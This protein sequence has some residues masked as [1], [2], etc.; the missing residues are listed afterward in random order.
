MV[1]CRDAGGQLEEDNT[2]ITSEIELQNAGIAEAKA[3]LEYYK[4]HEREVTQKVQRIFPFALSE[5]I[6][7][8]EDFL[9]NNLLASGLAT[10]CEGAG[11]AA[12]AC[13]Y[14]LVLK[15]CGHACSWRLRR[16]IEMPQRSC[17][18][19]VL[20]RLCRYVGGKQDV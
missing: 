12:L 13:D 11:L 3:Q 17:W 1:C 5:T 2:R 9:I 8:S 14:R 18:L 7:W 10:Q 20:R 4:G 6:W 19:L 15:A 16:A